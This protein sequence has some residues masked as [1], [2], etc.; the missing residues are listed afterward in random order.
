MQNKLIFDGDTVLKNK[1]K[2][3]NA[4]ANHKRSARYLNGT[5]EYRQLFDDFY[6][7]FKADAKEVVKLYKAGRIDKEE[8]SKRLKIGCDEYLR[9]TK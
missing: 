3:L 7:K 4:C 9:I 2:Y 8:A 1:R 6:E 5:P